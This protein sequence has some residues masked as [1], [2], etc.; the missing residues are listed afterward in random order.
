MNGPAMAIDPR[1]MAEVA[2]LDGDDDDVEPTGEEGTYLGFNPQLGGAEHDYDPQLDHDRRK[3][4]A[5]LKSRFEHIFAKYGRDFEGIG[6]EIDMAS[7]VIIVDNGH[8]RKMQHEVDTGNEDAPA[9]VPPDN[10]EQDDDAVDPQ[11]AESDADVGEEGYDS[12]AS[13][14]ASDSVS[15]TGRDTPETQPDEILDQMPSLRESVLDL[16]SRQRHGEGINQDT[17]D[18]LGM[19]I[20]KQLTDLM[21][22]QQKK[23]SKRKRNESTD[24]RWG[25]SD[26]PIPPVEKRSR[27]SLTPSLDWGELS[28]GRKSLWAPLKMPRRQKKKPI[29]QEPSP[30]P[31]IEPEVKPEDANIIPREELQQQPIR[32]C[33]NCQVSNSVIWRK[34]PDGIMCNA[35]GMY[36]YRYG[37]IREVGPPVANEE[38][39]SSEDSGPDSDADDAES[40]YS[41]N[42]SRH[43]DQLPQHKHDRFREDEEVLILKL[44]EID[45]LSWEKIAKYLPARTAYAVQCRYSKKIHNRPV[46]ARSLLANQ[47]Y[48]FQYD[49]NGLIVFTPAPVPRGFTDQEDE[50]LLKMREE[51]KLDWDIIAISFPEH[52]AKA[53]GIAFQPACQEDL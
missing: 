3:Q 27:R 24:D 43:R 10:E 49:A 11:L 4:K 33:Y 41:A 28:P 37:L 29:E 7:G 40:Q 25:V 38:S 51:E 36:H 53:L 47:G 23:V 32:R 17:I 2:V 22:R 14:D 12:T 34:G 45:R 5:K 13:D 50:L 16:Q 42:T 35:C 19:S 30:E 9:T 21:A 44:K 6:D 20:A 52:T 8:L 39:S 15:D 48:D 26:A 18:A 31:T 46:E 1:L